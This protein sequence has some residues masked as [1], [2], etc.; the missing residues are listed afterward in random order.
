MILFETR[1]T[2]IWFGFVLSVAVFV[3]PYTLRAATCN[4]AGRLDQYLSEWLSSGASVVQLTRQRLAG[5]TRAGDGGGGIDSIKKAYIAFFG[6]R[7][8]PIAEIG[9]CDTVGLVGRLN[10]V[11]GKIQ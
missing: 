10:H 9:Y 6:N 7:A 4:E 8:A 2:A 11:L 1:Q 3:L 5:S